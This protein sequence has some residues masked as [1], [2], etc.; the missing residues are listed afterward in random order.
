MHL[1]DLAGAF[2]SLPHNSTVFAVVSMYYVLNRYESIKTVQ[3]RKSMTV[4]EMIAQMGERVFEQSF[5]NYLS[6]TCQM[7]PGMDFLTEENG[8][9]ASMDRF[10]STIGQ[11]ELEALKQIEGNYGEEIKYATLF[12]FRAGLY[13]GFGQYFASQDIIEDGFEKRLAHGLFELS[14]MQRHPLFFKSGKRV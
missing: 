8:Y 9:K 11:P 3:R 5:Q 12:A 2:F 1:P 4:Q 10:T 14:G 6:A 13:S 7:L